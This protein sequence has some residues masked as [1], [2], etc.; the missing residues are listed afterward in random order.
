MA[1]LSSLLGSAGIG[2]A[3][4]KAVVRFSEH[5]GAAAGWTARAR[6]AARVP[7][8]PNNQDHRREDLDVIEIPIEIEVRRPRPIEGQFVES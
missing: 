2:G 5:L 1:D 3:I 6:R 8:A 4:G 7:V